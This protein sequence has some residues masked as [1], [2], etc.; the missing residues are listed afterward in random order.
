M[1]KRIERISLKIKSDISKVILL[2]KYSKL[3]ME[4]WAALSKGKYAKPWV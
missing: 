4:K 2:E 1:R 3:M